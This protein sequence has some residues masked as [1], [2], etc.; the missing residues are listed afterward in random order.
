M[1]ISLIGSAVFCVGL[2]KR[3]LGSFGIAALGAPPPTTARSPA[4]LSSM[5]MTLGTLLGGWMARGG[6][7]CAEGEA[8]LS[9]RGW[10][11]GEGAPLCVRGSCPEE[12]AC[13]QWRN[14][15]KLVQKPLKKKI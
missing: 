1:S 10:C 14:G 12:G 13:N 7:W 8:P 9:V 4:R 5:E 11:A 15:W 3:R 2:A 6:G